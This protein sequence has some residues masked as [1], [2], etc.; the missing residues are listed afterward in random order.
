MLEGYA[1]L[2]VVMLEGYAGLLVVA[3]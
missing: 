2:L 1:G 3:Y